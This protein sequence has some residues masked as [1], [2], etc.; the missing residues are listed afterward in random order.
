MAMILRERFAVPNW[1]HSILATDLAESVLQR[2]RKGVFSQLEMNR[3]LP[4]PYLVKYFLQQGSE[5]QLRPEVREMVDFRKMNLAEPW[6]NIPPM[7]IILMRNVL[8]YF[9][10]PVRQR[11]LAWVRR[12]LRPDGYLLMGAAETTL[13]LD[14]NFERVQCEK[15]VV[16]QVKQG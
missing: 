11:I 3:G 7:D 15:T 13:N 14:N 8:I 5:W 16:Y 9:D 4:V 12:V 6:S 1:Q 2:A 10:V